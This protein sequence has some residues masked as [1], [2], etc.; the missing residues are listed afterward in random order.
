MKRE[1]QLEFQKLLQK[2]SNC[3]QEIRRQRLEQKKVEEEI[4]NMVIT[5]GFK[6]FIKIDLNKL[7]R[8]AYRPK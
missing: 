6:E 5:C 7:M 1:I 3:L 2:R 8:E 4:E